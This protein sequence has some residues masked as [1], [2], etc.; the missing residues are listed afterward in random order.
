MN[1]NEILKRAFLDAFGVAVYVIG[2]VYFGNN[3]EEWFDAVQKN[4]L[5]PAFM[6]ILFIISACVTA[7]L[8]LLKPILLFIE[9][10][11][12]EAVHLFVYTL[13]FL[14]ILALVLVFL[15]IKL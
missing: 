11:R 15:I 5:A 6:I 8:V 9:G 2:F 1:K 10:A 7:S 13:G 14:I 4:W 3:L 12:K